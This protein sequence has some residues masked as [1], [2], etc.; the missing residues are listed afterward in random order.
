MYGV[1]DALQDGVIDPVADEH[2]INVTAPS[3]GSPLADER[4]PPRAL[5][6]MSPPPWSPMTRRTRPRRGH[7]VE[8]RRR[9]H[10]PETLHMVRVTLRL[11]PPR[12]PSR[13]AGLNILY[14]TTH[15][16][17]LLHGSWHS[18]WSAL[19]AHRRAVTV[20]SIETHQ[21]VEPLT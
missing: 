5:T 15:P 10:A 3:I 6:T 1:R 16:E 12:G 8:H 18:T 9:G 13:G 7:P 2:P 17:E 4:T 14:P 20:V 19:G 21:L 11:S